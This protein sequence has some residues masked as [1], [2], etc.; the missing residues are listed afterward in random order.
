MNVPLL[1]LLY[2]RPNT[3]EQVIN[4]LKKVKPKKIY[5]SINI[6]PLDK[7]NQD[8]NNYKKV[9]KLVDKINWKCDLN[10]KKRKKHLSAYN[11][12][13]NSVDWFFKNEK[14]GIVLEDDTVPNKSFFIFTSKLLK[15]YR[16]NKNIALICGAS[17]YKKK[18]FEN[19]SYI[20]SNM[21]HMWGYATWRRT[22]LDHDDKM[23]DWPKIKKNLFS[24]FTND[25]SHIKYWTKIF[26]DAYNKK[27]LAY[28][29]QMLYSNLKNKKLCIV[30]KINLVKNIGFNDGA[31][32]TLSK[33]W[34]SELENPCLINIKHPKFTT[35]DLGYDNWVNNNVFNIRYK[36]LN[37]KIKNY[38][39][40][41]YKLIF[42]T[43][44][45]LYGIIRYIYRLGKQS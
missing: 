28:D 34:Y 14:E 39:I 13:K 3:T 36:F 16:N 23:K 24:N 35:P 38:K 27:F 2:K 6:P 12:V 9:L 8:Y 19:G 26:S 1:L 21:A 37:K 11:S 42:K 43:L 33:E 45:I 40:F 44:K 20:F 17:F 30:P 15:K 10:I 7:N 25:K 4:A 29:Y 18:K 5:I 41:K 22:I 32:H 31:T